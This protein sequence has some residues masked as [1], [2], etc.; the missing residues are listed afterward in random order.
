MAS[1]GFPYRLE[2]VGVV[3]RHNPADPNEVEGVLNPDNCSSAL[4]LA[5]YEALPD[6]RKP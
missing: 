6:L 3:M 4:L 1:P 2:R 5:R